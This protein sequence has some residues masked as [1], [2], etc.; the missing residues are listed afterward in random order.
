M[1]AESGSTG[2]DGLGTEKVASSRAWKGG[3][4]RVSTSGRP[5]QGAFDAVEKRLSVWSPGLVKP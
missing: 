3:A 5:C 4:R 2:R 1:Y